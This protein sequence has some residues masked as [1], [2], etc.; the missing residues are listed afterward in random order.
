MGKNTLKI[1]TSAV[2]KLKQ[3]IKHGQ[4]SVPDDARDEMGHDSFENA[5]AICSLAFGQADSEDD[6]PPR[7]FLRFFKEF[8]L[9]LE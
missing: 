8:T 7:W 3:D 5:A 4:S 2:K 6:S 9:R 1:A